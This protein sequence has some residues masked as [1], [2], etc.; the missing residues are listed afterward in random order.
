MAENDLGDLIVDS[1]DLR[2]KYAVLRPKYDRLVSLVS[3]ILK[4]A[5]SHKNIKLHS[6]KQR[7]KNYNSFL[8]KVDRKKYKD[9]FAQCT[10]L[11]GSR[12]V[13]LFTSQIEEIKKIIEEEFD[14]IEV[15]N[16]KSTKKFDQFGYLSLHMLVKVPKQRLKHIEYADLNGLICEIQIRTILQEAW[17]EIEHY[18]NYKAT[19]E[20]HH[21]ELLRKIY[22]LAG[23]FEVADATF[24][25]IHKGFSKLVETKLEVKDGEITAVSLYKFSKQYFKWFTEDWDKTQER[26]FFRL[27]GELRKLSIKTIYDLKIVLDKQKVSLTSF[28]DTYRDK[29]KFSPAG[30]IRAALALEFGTKY[31]LVFGL[32]GFSAKIK[33]DVT[34][35]R[36]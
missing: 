1:I 25:D 5:I 3:L 17:A 9:P 16:K 36:Y 35:H 4:T 26:K 19:K 20:E 7:V 15:T 14:V 18:L 24:E 34:R 13:C 10:D 2:S 29:T 12:L 32:K 22:S 23:M 31:D 6:M 21:E 28:K 30:L 33:K 27:S 11:A 8:E